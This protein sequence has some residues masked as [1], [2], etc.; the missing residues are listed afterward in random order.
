MSEVR[1]PARAVLG[2]IGAPAVL[3]RFTILSCRR[4][5]VVPAEVGISGRAETAT[6]NP[7]RMPETISAETIILD[8]SALVRN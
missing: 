4:A 6:P 2:L 7:A 1:R 5:C 8:V 3:D